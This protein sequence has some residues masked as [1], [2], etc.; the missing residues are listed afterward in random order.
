MVEGPGHVPYDQI[1]A[2]MK[3]EKRLC[4]HAPFYVLGPLVTDIAPG[5]DHITQPSAARSPPSP[6]RTSSA[7]SRRPSIWPCRR[8][9]MSTRASSR[10]ASPPMPLT[11][12]AACRAHA[13]GTSRW[14]RRAKSSTG[15]ARWSSP[16]TGPRQEEARRPQPSRRRRLLHVR[17]LLRRRDHQQVL[18]Q[19]ELPVPGL[20]CLPHARKKAAVRIDGQQLFACACYL[21]LL[22]RSASF[23]ADS[24]S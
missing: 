12:C 10:A 13:S 8:S 20:I 6:A 23:W 2:N 18:P 22:R 3:L 19:R 5:Y 14:P 21:I 1:E 17:R 7:T 15:T 11:S 16:S 4:R 24:S 9:R